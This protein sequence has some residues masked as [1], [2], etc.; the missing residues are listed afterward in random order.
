MIPEED[1]KT[2]LDVS[3]TNLGCSPLRLHGVK[4]RLSCGKSG[5]LSPCQKVANKISRLLSIPQSD[6]DEVSESVECVSCND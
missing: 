2:S 5:R 6:V 3:M 4:D 1:L